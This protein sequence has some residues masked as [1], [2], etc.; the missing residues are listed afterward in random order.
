M[1]SLLGR[2][3]AKWG[4]RVSLIS[5]FH[6]GDSP[7]NVGRCETFYN[8][9]RTAE[10]AAKFRESCDNHEQILNLEKI[11]DALQVPTSFGV[12][13]KTPVELSCTYTYRSCM[14]V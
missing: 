4:E 11:W 6:S 1:Q 7:E 14:N 9:T 5:E 12:G 10:N 2:R 3:A 8:R 13:I